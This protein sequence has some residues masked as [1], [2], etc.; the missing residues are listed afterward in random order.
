MIQ[1]RKK[2]LFFAILLITLGS[3]KNAETNNSESCYLNSNVK[4]L[5]HDGL[6]REYLCYIPS[7]YDG[8]SAVPLMLNFHGFGGS[9]SDY[10]QEADMRSLAESETFI[11]VYPQGSCLDGSSHWNAC[12]NGGD[13]KSDADDFGFIESII[14][15]ISSQ[16]NINMERIY[17]AGYSNGGMMAYG[18][19]NYKSDLIAAV[20]SVSGAMLDCTGATN[21]PMPVVH[22]H[23]TSD[24]VIPYNGGNG[25]N[26]VQSTLDYWINFNNTNISPTITVDNSGGIT[27]EHYVYDQG[28]GL[29]SVEHYKYI[30]GDHVWFNST[31]QDQNTSALV[32][33]F[34]SRYDIN[35]L[36]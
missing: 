33:N 24:A 21:H 15:E 7:S 34:V 5:V 23:G 32:W 12:S 10:M 3:C 28:D 36:R 18:L 16:Y 8:T 26:S 22:L 6:N 20:A 27:I 2:A 17:A 29:V 25:W 19:A 13:N 35:G 9:A 31:F 11:L 14:N 1:A 4:T 30:G